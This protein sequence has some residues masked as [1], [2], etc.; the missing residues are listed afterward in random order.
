MYIHTEISQTRFLLV[1]ITIKQ[2]FGSIQSN[3]LK[4]KNGVNEQKRSCAFEHE[5][6]KRLE[7]IIYLKIGS[8]TNH[9][10]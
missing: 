1:S 2:F 6:L 5:N 10:G 8:E 9:S 3:S 7:S 4:L